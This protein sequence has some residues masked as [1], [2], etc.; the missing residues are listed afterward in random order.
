M[1]YRQ[2][3]LKAVYPALMWFTKLTGKNATELSG[4]KEPPVPFYM[5]QAISINGDTIDFSSFKGKKVLLVNTASDCGY[6]NQYD[7][8]QKLSETY[9]DKLVVLGFPANDF[10]EQEKGT[11]KEIAEFCK[12]NFGVTFPLMQKSIVIK[13]PQQNPVFQWLT[14]AAKNGWNDKAPTWNFSKYLV[15]E[16]GILTNYFDPSVSP[17]S[18]AVTKAIE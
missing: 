15:N 7:D 2:K 16:K 18:D 9:K 13:S 8:L 3:V 17:L 6:T 4:I 1:T 11:D 12:V 5:Q 10:K 14:E